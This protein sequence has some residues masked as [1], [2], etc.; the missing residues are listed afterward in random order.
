VCAF[1]EQEAQCGNVI[2]RDS[3]SS[4]VAV[5]NATLTT[6][7]CP[8]ALFPADGIP[9][10]TCV[11]YSGTQSY[12]EPAGLAY[13]NADGISWQSALLGLSSA[14][15]LVF[16]GT[17]TFNPGT[18]Q[19]TS[20]DAYKGEVDDPMSQSPYVWNRNNP[21]KYADPSGFDPFEAGQQVAPIAPATA[22]GEALAEKGIQSYVSRLAAVIRAAVKVPDNAPQ[23]SEADAAHMFRNATNHVIDSPLNRALIQ[24]TAADPANLIPGSAGT[25]ILKDGAILQ[26]FQQTLQNGTQAWAWTR[27]GVITNGG[28]NAVPRIVPGP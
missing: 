16:Q 17:R 20:P 7:L 13:V 19:W 10:A 18:S 4:M 27:N 5:R 26:K 28:I 2:D 1:V 21:V 22:L 23:I 14:V 25:R 11:N 6:G 8:S 24:R 15:S 3:A 12:Y 9:L